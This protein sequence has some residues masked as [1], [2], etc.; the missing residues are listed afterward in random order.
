MIIDM[1]THQLTKREKHNENLECEILGLRKELEKTKYHNLRFAKG[2]QTLNE[3]IKVQCSPLINTGIGYTKESSQSQKSSASTKSYLNTAK[4]SEQ[5][6]N[7][8]RRP[9]ITHK[10]FTPRMNIIRRFNQQV[11]NS[12]RFY[13]QRTFFNGKCFSCHNFGHKAAQ[14]FLTKPS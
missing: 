12:K 9:K 11:N 1:L 14:V 7:H 10:L 5:Y 4:T 6:V 13:D 8:Q 3:I 2:S